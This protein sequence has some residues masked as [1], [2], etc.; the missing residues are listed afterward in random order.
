MFKI[1]LPFTVKQRYLCIMKSKGTKK[2]MLLWKLYLTEPF[3]PCQS[4]TLIK[5]KIATQD[6][7]F[8]MNNCTNLHQNTSLFTHKVEV[9]HYLH[10]VP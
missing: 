8:S 9:L 3:D 1:C 4:N 2:M 7:E 5:T 6:K 10:A